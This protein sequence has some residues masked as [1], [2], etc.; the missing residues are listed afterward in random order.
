M[1]RSNQGFLK[2]IRPIFTPFFELELVIEE[3]LIEN[4]GI[5]QTQI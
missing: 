3:V 4:Q 1:T 5:T 2:K